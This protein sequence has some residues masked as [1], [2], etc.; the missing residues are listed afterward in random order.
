MVRKQSAHLLNSIC[1]I[2]LNSHIAQSSLS[3]LGSVAHAPKILASSKIIQ[4]FKGHC[5]PKAV[6]L[7]AV[8]FKF[9]FSLS[10]REIEEILLI[11]GVSAIA[12]D[13]QDF[14]IEYAAQLTYSLNYSLPPN[15]FRRL[16]PGSMRLI[17][18]LS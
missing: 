9:R 6:I 4:M 7:Q 10:Y 1:F 15:V 3:K 18:Y 17:G 13:L 14:V 16:F 5:F 8:Y 11:R 12:D 2:L